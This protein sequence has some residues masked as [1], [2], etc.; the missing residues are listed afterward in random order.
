MQGFRCGYPESVEK[1]PNSPTPEETERQVKALKRL[2]D[3]EIDK[4]LGPQ[5]GCWPL[6]VAIAGV[7]LGLAL[8]AGLL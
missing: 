2:L 6:L 1:Q 5:R 4:R 7:L 3:A 8:L